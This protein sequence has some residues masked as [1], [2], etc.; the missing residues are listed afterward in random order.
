MFGESIHHAQEHWDYD[1]PP[2]GYREPAKIYY[3]L[4]VISG[5]DQ[6]AYYLRK[7]YMSEEDYG[8]AEKW[9][10]YAAEHHI[11][12]SYYELGKI[13]QTLWKKEEKEIYLEKAYEWKQKELRE[14]SNEFA[15]YNMAEFYKDILKAVI[16]SL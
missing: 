16:L 2:L 11:S 10:L 1:Y 9:M 7:S 14:N 13:Y 3:E 8:Q 15:W 4:A 5:Y 6:A 12:N